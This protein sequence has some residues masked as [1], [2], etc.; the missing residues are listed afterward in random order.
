MNEE[1][2]KRKRLLSSAYHLFTTKGINHTTIQDIVDAAKVAKGTFYLYFEDKYHIQEELIIDKSKE[3]F[4]A[5]LEELRNHKIK[6]FDDQI[7]FIIDYVIDE[8]IK[9]P[10]IL[11]FITKD[12]ALGIYNDKIT[13][14]LD[15]ESL[16]L[17]SMFLKGIKDNKIKLKNPEITLFMIIEFVSSTLYS[18]V[19]NKINTDI[20]EYKSY[21]HK[22]IK[23]M[24]NS[25]Y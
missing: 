14:L 5:A 16:G 24:I 12:L 25:G 2:P 4:N 13:M 3:L 8:I 15:T 11:N 19:T 7:I 21:I 9:T 6:K 20:K 10:D 18:V 1:T 22:I 17:K 23:N